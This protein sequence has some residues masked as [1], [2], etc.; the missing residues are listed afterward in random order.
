MRSSVR[1]RKCQHWGA[2]DSFLPKISILNSN[3]GLD[4]GKLMNGQRAVRSILAAIPLA[5]FLIVD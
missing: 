3:S 2:I 4:R 5:G 1:V